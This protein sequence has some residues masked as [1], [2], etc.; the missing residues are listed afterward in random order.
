MGEKDSFVRRVK[1]SQEIN[2]GKEIEQIEDML[3]KQTNKKVELI[4][5]FLVSNSNLNEVNI[6]TKTELINFLK[7]PETPYDLIEDI[8]DLLDQTFS[9]GYPNFI[10]EFK[11]KHNKSVSDLIRTL[12]TALPDREEV[13][14]YENS[15]TYLKRIGNVKEYEQEVKLKIQYEKFKEERD[16]GGEVNKGPLELKSTFDIVFDF[17]AM[18]CYVKCGDRRQ[19]GAVERF[20][21]TK[22]LGVFDTFEGYSFKVKHISTV[23][24]N[25]YY[26]DKQTIILLDFI[27]NEIN[28]N[29]Y[30]ITDYFTISF[31]NSQSDKVKSVRLG[32]TNLLE[33]PEVSDRISQGDKIKSVRFQ[34]RKE[35]EPDKFNFSTVKIDFELTLKITF[36]RVRNSRH[37]KSDI[38]HIVYALN[39]SLAKTHEEDKVKKRLN[40]ITRKIRIQESLFLK[41]TLAEI[42][43][44]ALALDIDETSKEKIGDM[45]NEYIAEGDN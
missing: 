31:S 18:L 14:V 36:S 40:E 8:Y 41:S 38:Q 13:A 37:I 25:E 10:F 34:L 9:R 32:G 4:R 30:Q 29:D 17:E 15:H 6:N 21:Q 26:L 27:E 39:E 28:K 42:R 19:L 5:F 7:H 45:L 3:K 35:L 16:F 1:M 12:E 2:I 23:V 20:L 33:S 24:E 22:V 11:L 43:G 44:K